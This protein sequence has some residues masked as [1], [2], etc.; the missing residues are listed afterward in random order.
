MTTGEPNYMWIQ[1]ES[2]R[3]AEHH[4]KYQLHPRGTIGNITPTTTPEKDITLHTIINN[5][6]QT[7]KLTHQPNTT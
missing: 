1:A 5:E 7:G 2:R 6:I 4:I 3:E